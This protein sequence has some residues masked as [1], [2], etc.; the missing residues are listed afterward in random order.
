MTRVETVVSE[1]LT[2]LPV[3]PAEVGGPLLAG[4]DL[5]P[6]RTI[7]A[8]ASDPAFIASVLAGLVDIPDDLRG[9]P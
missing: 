7:P 1:L 4:L 2:V 5:A 9:Q 3:I 8:W 6:R